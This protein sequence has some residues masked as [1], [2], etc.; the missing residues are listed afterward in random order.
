MSQLEPFNAII[1]AGGASTRFGRNKLNERLGSRTL[2]EQV[3]SSIADAEQ[4]VIV[5]TP[6][7][8][9]SAKLRWATERT[10]DSLLVVSE[11]P[12]GSGPAMGIAAGAR[13]LAAAASSNPVLVVGGDMP[14][15][16]TAIPQLLTGLIHAPVATLV[17]AEEVQQQLASVWRLDQLLAATTATKPGDSVRS[18]FANL[19]V[20]FV[21]EQTGAAFDVDKQADLDL[22]N[23]R[24]IGD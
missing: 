9:D 21:P 20:A 24:L 7:T 11:E 1:L 2:L 3:V 19:E 22:A 14:F 10:T 16:A 18:L 5:G 12:A 8:V 4:I 15:V 17:D 23:S 13:A 6:E